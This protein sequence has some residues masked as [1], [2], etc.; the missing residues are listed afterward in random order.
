MTIIM[1][2]ITECFE[3]GSKE[4]EVKLIFTSDRPILCENLVR[5]LIFC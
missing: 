5:L 4:N 2:R 3:C 1:V